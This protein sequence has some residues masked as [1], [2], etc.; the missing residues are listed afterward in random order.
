MPVVSTAKTNS[1]SRPRSRFTT[2]CHRSS[3]TVVGDTWFLAIVSIACT[4]CAKGRREARS[5]R[6]ESCAQIAIRIYTRRLAVSA[7]D[8]QRIWVFDQLRDLHQILHRRR[9]VDD[10]MIVG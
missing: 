10:A 5:I 8:E 3:A 4:S 6:A 9:A 2:A 7:F 1:P